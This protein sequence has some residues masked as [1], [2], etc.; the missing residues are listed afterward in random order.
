MNEQP[1]ELYEHY[2]QLLRNHLQARIAAQGGEDL[3]QGREQQGE[4]DPAAGGRRIDTMP[5][6]VQGLYERALHHFQRAEW[7]EA[8]Q[9]VEELRAAGYTSRDID[10][11]L[12]DAQLKAHLSSLSITP[13]KPP[14]PSGKGQR[15][16]V[17]AAGVLLLLLL[18]GGGWF[19]L[20]APKAEKVSLAQTVATATSLP[21]TITPPALTA[22]SLPTATLPPPTTTL[23]PPTTMPVDLAPQAG[24]LQI[25]LPPGQEQVIRTPHNIVLIV[26]ASGSMLGQIDGQP[27][28]DLAR[29]AL[30]TVITQ[31]PD[32]ARL[33]IRTYG[34]Q[35]SGDCSDLSLVKPLDVHPKEEIL[36][37]LATIRPVAQGM[38][39]LADSLQAVDQD[40]GE[41]QG[42]AVV[43]LVSDGAETCDRDPVEVAGWLKSRRPEL[44]IH[45]IGFDIGDPEAGERLR[46]IAETGG[47][48]Y[49]DASGAEQLTAALQEAIQLSYQVVDEQ[50]RVVVSGSVGGA[51]VSIAPG[52]YRLRLAS[53]EPLEVDVE[54]ESGHSLVLLLQS[55]GQQLELIETRRSGPAR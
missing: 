54:I 38:T 26:D 13:L 31:V 6:S 36:A 50:G 41:A 5:D 32:D 21:P 28:I 30:E 12:D 4:H 3:A 52:R 39:P 16:L 10:E 48:S 49:F 27:K 18:A 19:A 17:M 43:I 1:P 8:I 2:R 55:Q 33:A 20:I 34:T 45:V 47:G 11:I 44:R 42:S 9:I 23:P 29:R 35:R 24:S 51:A 22:T 15:T 53:D 25:L 7:H 14:Q 40:L 37:S 46:A